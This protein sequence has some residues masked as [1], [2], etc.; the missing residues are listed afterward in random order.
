VGMA[1][2]LL[3]GTAVRNPNDPRRGAAVVDKQEPG[4]SGRRR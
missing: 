3:C 1:E 2:R 4:W